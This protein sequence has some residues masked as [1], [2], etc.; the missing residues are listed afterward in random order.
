VACVLAGEYDFDMLSVL[1]ALRVAWKDGDDVTV[2]RRVLDIHEL[3][4]RRNVNSEYAKRRMD[5]LKHEH[6][7]KERERKLSEDP[8]YAAAFRA[9]TEAVNSGDV[10]RVR[11]A[12]ARLNELGDKPPGP[13]PQQAEPTQ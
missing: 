1:K 13:D 6:E 11:T 10:E 3:L 5:A 7:K 4:V 9:F 8:E 2:K 12:Q